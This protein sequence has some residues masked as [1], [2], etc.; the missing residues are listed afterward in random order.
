MS[1]PSDLAA[2]AQRV[3]ADL[4]ELAALT[5]DAQ[6]AQRVAWGPVWRK[7]RAWF[8]AKVQQ[9]LGLTVSSDSAGNHHVVLPGSSDATVIVASH[10][11]SVP[12][13]GWL[14]GCLGVLAG[15]EALR[16]QAGRKDRKATLRLID[17]ADEE[18][19]RFGRSLVGSG[20]AG[21][22]LNIEDIRNLKDRQ[23]VTQADA[24]KEN[25]VDIE[26]MLNAHRELKQIKA[27]AYLELHIEQGP[28][29][30]SLN[31]PTG[32]VLGTF[33][34]E[35]HMLKFSGQAAH[36][37]STPIP[38]RRDAFLAAAQFALE[39][40]QIGLRHSKPGA[41]VVCTCGIVK[42]EPCIVTAVPGVCEISIDQRALDARV[43]AAMLA[44]ARA[45]AEK[46]A[47]DNNV[48]LEWK[49]L[50][51]IEPRPF[52]PHLLQLCEEAVRAVTGDATRLPSG[53]LHD[54]A[55][56]V[57]HMPT[58]MMFAYSARGLSHC[59]EEDTPLPHLEKTIQAFLLLVD[60]TVASVDT[61]PK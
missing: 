17:W 36:S 53:P 10:L 39:V 55:E 27:R 16:R 61:N 58:V 26:T 51:T 19:A 32:V 45:A 30:E 14:D 22:S 3:I 18:G 56:M 23:G 12:N 38:M 60:K 2:S 7:A 15:L 8:Q 20:A 47:R 54:A 21:G 28:V 52:D 57:P 50:W 37:G 49:K 41:N 48:T 44:E 9:E 46:A 59:K 5:S 1:T 29:L 40:R 31:K 34:V 13:G 42:V 6:G 11:D 35:R 33:G 24:L 43:L 25:G 4:K